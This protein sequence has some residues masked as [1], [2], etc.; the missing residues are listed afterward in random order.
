MRPEQKVFTLLSQAKKT[1]MMG[2]RTGENPYHRLNG[3]EFDN[4]ITK[5][6]VDRRGL[7]V[8]NDYGSSDRGRW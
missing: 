8:L 4:R 2:Y 3:S 6:D 1:L 5:R 7:V